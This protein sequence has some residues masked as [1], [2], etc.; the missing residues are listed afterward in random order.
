[1]ARLSRTP[2]QIAKNTWLRTRIGPG[3]AFSMWIR[4]PL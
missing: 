2:D 4:S 3:C 1:M